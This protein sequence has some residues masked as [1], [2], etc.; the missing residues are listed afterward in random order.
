MYDDTHTFRGVLDID[1]TRLNDFD[2][3]DKE[4][5]G[6]IIDLLMEETQDL[7]L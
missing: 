3:D 4:G 6:R 2:E 5:L 1:S 7:F